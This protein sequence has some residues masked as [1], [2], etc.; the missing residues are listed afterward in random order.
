MVKILVPGP[1]DLYT[2]T[3]NSEARYRIPIINAN[4]HKT[5]FVWRFGRCPTL[6]HTNLTGKEQAEG[7]SPINKSRL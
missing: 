4:Y 5:S 1:F 2:H 3:W 7:A 6:L